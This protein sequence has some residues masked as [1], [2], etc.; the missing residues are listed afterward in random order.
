MID[1]GSDL[2]LEAVIE[3]VCEADVICLYFP[4]L[5]QTL[6][7]DTRTAPGIDAL[8]CVVPMVDS[9]AARVRSL[10]RL[11]PQLPRPLSITMIPWTRRPRSLVASGVWEQLLARLEDVAPAQRCLRELH[12]SELTELG[13]AIVGREGYEAIWSRADA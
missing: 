8:V 1:G 10:R 2:D 7:V 11:R 9:A 5:G 12:A 3:N 13:R 4:A 6:V